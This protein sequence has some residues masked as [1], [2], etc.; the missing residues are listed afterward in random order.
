MR[1]LSGKNTKRLSKR[2]E[3]ALAGD[4]D[5]LVQKGS[6]SLPWAKGDVRKR[7]RFRAECKFTRAKSYTL[8][9]ATLDKIRSECAMDETPVLDVTFL[10]KDGRTDEHWIMIPYDVW[11][12][13]QKEK[14]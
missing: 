13:Q 7:G 6:G 8:T 12:E 1:S 5:S 9:I 14:P 2:Q 10:N 11:L 4:T 3:M